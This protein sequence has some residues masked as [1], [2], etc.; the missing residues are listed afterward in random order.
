MGQTFEASVRQAT[1]RFLQGCRRSDRWYSISPALFGGFDGDT[2][3]FF[4]A[5]W[6]GIDDA[7]GSDQGDDG[8][9]AQFRAFLE[10]NILPG[11]FG[12]SGGYGQ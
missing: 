6:A 9:D 12:N 7:S 10:Q 1:D 11:G 8:R 3:P 4:N 5:V 2:I